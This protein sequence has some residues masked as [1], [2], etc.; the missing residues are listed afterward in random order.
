MSCVLGDWDDFISEIYSSKAVRGPIEH[1]FL[2]NL[3]SCFRVYAQALSKPCA[4]F[5]I[6]VHFLYL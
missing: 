6:V 1:V 3:L 4:L 5:R 2:R